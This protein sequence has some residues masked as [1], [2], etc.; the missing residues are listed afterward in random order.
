MKF[1][2]T[3]KDPDGVYES[4]RD[5]FGENEVPGKAHAVM[6]KYI[7]HEEYITIEFESDNQTAKVLEN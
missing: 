3:F 2:I 5:W 7:Q 6:D 4:L 1:E